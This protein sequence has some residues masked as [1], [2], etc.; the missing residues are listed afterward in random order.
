MLELGT[1]SNGDA[2]T[3]AYPDGNAA[4]A[5]GAAAM[6]MQG[7]WGIGEIA[8]VN[9]KAKVGTFALPATDNAA[10]AKCRVNLDL[11][12]WIPKGASDPAA[13]H[14]FMSY[15]L[16]LIGDRGR[17]HDDPRCT[18]GRIPSRSP[19]GGCRTGS[20]SCAT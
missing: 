2:G 7:P 15:L 16:T 8:K 3:R 10:D 5:K 12:F 11:A 1:Y 14:R 20:C 4:F 19:S 6:Y 13:A 18:I 9:P 17:R